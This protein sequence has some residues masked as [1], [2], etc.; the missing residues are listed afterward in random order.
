LVRIPGL[1][2]ET[3]DHPPGRPEASLGHDDAGRP[4]P[5]GDRQ[6][7]VLRDGQQRDQALAMAVLRDVTDSGRERRRHAAG[8]DRGRPG[9]D[10][11]GVRPPQAGE[12]L[13]ERH[14][15]AA[16][17]AGQADQLAA[18][19]GE[20]DVVVH[21]GEPQSLC[22]KRD[23]R[24]L[25]HGWAPVRGGKPGRLAG[26]RRDERV[27]VDLDH[28]PGEHPPRVAQHR[29]GV[30]HLVH[31][32]Q[33]VGDEQHRD[34]GLGHRPHPGEE[35]FDRGSVELR[36]G[37]VEDDEASAD[38]QRPGDL[39]QLALLDGEIAGQAAGV[40]VQAVLLQQRAGPPAQPPPV[41]PVPAPVAP[42]RGA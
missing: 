26:H 19:D 15:P 30:A 39:H 8:L 10:G 11:A 17:R 2:V 40:D 1:D 7:A 5:V 16:A 38:R 36:G 20:V 25:G 4:E 28:R 34:A 35:P 21:A 22:L 14:L 23:G 12:G 18:A 3:L 6:R 13:A 41:D 27:P 29:H 37:L 31:L 42:G 24:V 9:G 33:V 32:L